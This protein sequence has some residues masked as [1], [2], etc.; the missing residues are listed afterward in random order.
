[1]V[2]LCS[3]WSS[4]DSLNRMNRTKPKV[5]RNIIRFFKPYSIR[6][7]E[8]KN[9]F[10]LFYWLW[11]VNDG[12]VNKTI[13]NEFDTGQ[14]QFNLNG[15]EM[16]SR[17]VRIR[18]KL[19]VWVW[20]TANMNG[21]KMKFEYLQTTSLPLHYLYLLSFFLSFVSFVDENCPKNR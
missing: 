2:R 6:F 1:M 18:F 20:Y 9:Y 17:Q 15:F 14:V 21:C 19:F 7:N 3:K 11:R 5:K 16:K 12:I 10:W 8:N 4:A 13:S